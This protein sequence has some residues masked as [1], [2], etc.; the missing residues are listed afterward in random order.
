M[1]K[2]FELE[3]GSVIIYE[4]YAIVIVNEGISFRIKENE[5]LTT[6]LRDIFK[7][8]YFTLISYRIFSFS[9]DPIVYYQL[10]KLDALIGICVVSQD[11]SNLSIVE[12]EKSFY[13]K[14]FKL[15]SS[16]DE[17]KNWAEELSDSCRLNYSNS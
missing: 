14:E 2:D 12:F 4:N 3:F 17:A 11:E 9:V 5:V 16:I 1:K 15:L 7:D 6:L 10:S 8:N 13:Q